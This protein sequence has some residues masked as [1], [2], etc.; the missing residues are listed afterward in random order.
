MP[1]HTLAS[2]F[3]FTIKEH[4][5]QIDQPPEIGNSSVVRIIISKNDNAEGII[6]FDPLYT[7]LQGR[8]MFHFML[9][10]SSRIKI[11]IVNTEIMLP[12][13]NSVLD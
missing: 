2:G 1:S 7:S 9:H 12:I 11:T 8:L 10:S 4:G 3:D 5:L 6:E 13:Q